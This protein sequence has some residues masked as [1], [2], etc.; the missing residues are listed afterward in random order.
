M[1]D[2]YEFIRNDDESWTY[3]VDNFTKTLPSLKECIDEVENIKMERG[4]V[5]A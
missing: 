4:V 2:S 5:T 1:N 3:K